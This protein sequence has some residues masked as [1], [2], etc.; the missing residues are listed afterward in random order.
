MALIVAVELILKLTCSCTKTVN[1]FKDIE[2]FSDWVSTQENNIDNSG[3]GL[4]ISLPNS[5]DKLNDE[6]T[7][8]DD[9]N[10]DEISIMTESVTLG[11]MKLQEKYYGITGS[12]FR[13]YFCTTYGASI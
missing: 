13:R 5:N 4:G 1:D 7:T 3:N 6:T 8:V 11:Q 9:E 10:G 2:L 12:Q